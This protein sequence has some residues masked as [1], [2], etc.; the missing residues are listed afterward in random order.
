[1]DT[2]NIDFVTIDKNW[3]KNIADYHF[4]IYH[5]SGWIAASAIVDKGKPQGIIAHYKNKKVFLPIDQ[6]IKT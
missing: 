4:D 3:D 1:M 2:V 6:F 5:L